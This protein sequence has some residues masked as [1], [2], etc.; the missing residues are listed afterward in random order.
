MNMRRFYLTTAILY[1][2]G[3]PHIGF[4]LERVQADVLARH[5]RLLGDDVRFLS[6]TDDNS[7]K[8]VEAAEAAGLPAAEFVNAK[9]ERF[10]AL[11][12]PLARRFHPHEHR[13]AAP[14]RRRAPVARVRY[15][16]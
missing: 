11:R 13:S 4:A 2:N 1:V 10:A 5:R 6:S 15:D 3:D 9:A 16:G 7:L 14:A 12:E 8:N